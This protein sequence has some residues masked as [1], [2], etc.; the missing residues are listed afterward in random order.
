MKLETHEGLY[1]DPVTVDLIARVVAGLTEVGEAFVILIDDADT[2]TYVQAAGTIGEEFLVE[3]RDGRAGDHY[4]GDR[5]LSADDLVALLA[6][7]LRRA[8]DW[9]A[10][11]TWHRVR[12]DQPRPVA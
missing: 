3:Y 8:P 2:E 6:G 7:Y 12:V 5:R 9:R 11:I 1:L 4:R 10:A